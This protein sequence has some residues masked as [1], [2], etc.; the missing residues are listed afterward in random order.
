MRPTHGRIPVDGVCPFAPSFDTVGWMARDI[1]VLARAGNVLLAGSADA[2]P[3]EN[4][5]EQQR[6]VRTFVQRRLSQLVPPGIALCLPTAP[7]AAPVRHSPSGDIE[8]ALRARAISLLCIAGL[9]GLP[10]LTLPLGTLDGCPLGLSMVGAR[11]TDSAL[12]AL[13]ASL[14]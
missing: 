8:V 10:Q 13:A 5:V 14:E 4:D 3:P 1:G 7:S 12:L 9:G 2:G 11:G 6:T